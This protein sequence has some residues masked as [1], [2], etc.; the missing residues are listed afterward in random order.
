LIYEDIKKVEEIVEKLNEELYAIDPKLHD[1]CI[2][3]EFSGTGSTMGIKFCGSYIWDDQNDEREWNEESGKQ[4]PPLEEH[5]R[6]EVMQM[7]KLVSKINV[8]Q[9]SDE[10]T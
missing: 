6:S 8:A 7:V 4:V 10:G 3:L 2:M 1:E 5:I 9:S